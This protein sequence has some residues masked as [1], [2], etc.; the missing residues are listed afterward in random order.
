[1]ALFF[2]G[3]LYGDLCIQILLIDFSVADNGYYLYADDRVRQLNLSQRPFENPEAST[4]NDDGTILDE[5][6]SHI[7]HICFHIG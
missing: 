7:I 2:G 5:V 4:S 6:A 1:M 3:H